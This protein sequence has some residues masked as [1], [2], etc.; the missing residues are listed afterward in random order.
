MHSGT[1]S[2]KIQDGMI[3][4]SVGWMM[5]QEMHTEFKLKTSTKGPICRPKR[6]ESIMNTDLNRRTLENFKWLEM[7]QYLVH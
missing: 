6:E 4:W 2:P 3:V 1:M 5:R 7:T